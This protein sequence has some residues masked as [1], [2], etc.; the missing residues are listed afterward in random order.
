MAGFEL[1][2]AIEWVRGHLSTEV[3]AEVLE[4]LRAQWQVGA[5][6]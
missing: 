1:G 2:A 3:A 6:G 4:K 5:R